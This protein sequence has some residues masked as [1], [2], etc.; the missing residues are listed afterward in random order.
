MRDD[1][2]TVLLYEFREDVATYLQ[3]SPA[4]LP[5]RDL[6]GLISF[7]EEH[8]ETELR[9]FGQDIFLQAEE[10]TD[11][12]AYEA[13]RANSFRLAGPEGID[14]LLAEND[15]EFLIAPTEGPAWPTDLVLGDHF[16]GGTRAGSLAA[17]AG[18]PHLTIPMGDVEGLPVG[19]SFIGKKWADHSVLRVGAAYE[20][21]RSVELSRPS[22][23]PWAPRRGND[24]D[25]KAIL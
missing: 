11:R 6:A 10:A 18:Y 19:L 25:T 8:A 24:H 7:N 9:W 16:G 4:D 23:R 13:A 22:F 20:R 2:F 5:A 21:A 1:E 12:K 3:G 17:I 15:A 14:R